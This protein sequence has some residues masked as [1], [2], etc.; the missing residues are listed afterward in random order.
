MGNDTQKKDFLPEFLFLCFI[1]FVTIFSESVYANGSLQGDVIKQP[2]NVTAVIIF[3][4]FVVVTLLITAWAAKKT[5][6][7]QDFYT[8]GGGI[9]AWQNG[10]AISGDFL[11]A[12][13]MLGITSAIYT[14]GADGL[15]LVIG[16]LGAWPIV[17]FLI[18]ERLRNLGRYTF[19][20]VL[21]YRLD[22]G[23]IRPLAA[24]ASLC[25]LIFYLIAQL[26][27]AG[28]LVELLFGLDYWIAVTSV[29]LLMVVYV[30]LG[31]MLA[32]TWVQFIK[33]FLLIT[34]GTLLAVLLLGHF[35]FSLNAIIA[36]ATESYP[37]DR[38][39]VEVG[40]WIK[41]PI[42]MLSVGVSLL[43][44]FVGLPHILMR[45]FTVKDAASSRKSAFYAITIIGY[46]QLLIVLIGFGAVALIVGNPDY[47]NADGSILGG[48]NMVV[49]HVAHM[50][51]GNVLFGFISAVTFAT[52]LA[53]VSGLTISAAAT[54]AH[55]IYASTFARA[56]G[57]QRAKNEKLISR[58]T[59]IGM[60]LIAMFFG[61]LFEHQNVVFISNMS[62]AIAG[63]C[64]APVLLAALYWGGLTS[65]G[66]VA[67]VLIGLLSS[68]LLIILG[69]Q[70]WVGV[71]G[72]DTAIFPYTYPTLISIPLAFLALWFFSK[73]DKSEK[74][75]AERSRFEA[76]V[77]F[78]ETGFA[79]SDAVRH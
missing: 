39:V 4:C 71:L 76:Q 78:S 66:A 28:K 36:K 38:S 13:T 69:P 2:L 41:D 79:V 9:P 8:A 15:L 22:P 48:G 64:N 50:L 27:G 5:Q 49:L 14:F 47:H 33:A 1:G 35:D 12:A 20:D 34:G 56:K 25:V 53:V 3:S 77:V 46:F 29:S 63:S 43:F 40:H 31:G 6:T 51:G 74:A 30:A 70:V 62:L 44:G 58:L 24:I 26:V 59:V 68:V 11:S 42:S 32:A 10:V 73:L 45:L 55:D 19:I 7:N 23:L 21:S 60:G 61:L 57:E 17:L 75:Y 54:I 16:T 72:N 65:Q 18:A 37:G 67:G 52:I